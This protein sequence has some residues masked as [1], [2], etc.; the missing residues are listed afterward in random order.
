MNSPFLLIV[1]LLACVVRFSIASIGDENL[2]IIMAMVNVVAFDYVLLILMQD[3]RH[4]V[5]DRMKENQ[6]P[7]ETERKSIKKLNIYYGLFYII[8]FLIIGFVCVHYLHSSAGNDSISIM[9]LVISICSDKLSEY[10]GNT[11][12]TII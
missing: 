5:I 1:G 12:Y 7:E 11:I 10:L 6:Y 9:A 4:L 8:I 2:L 3:A